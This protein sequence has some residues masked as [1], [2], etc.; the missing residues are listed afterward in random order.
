MAVIFRDVFQLI[1]N[2]LYLIGVLALSTMGITLTFKTANATNF[3]Q[4]ITST[5][6]AYMAGLLVRD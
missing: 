3:A 1:L 5:I 4:A 6:G 2:N